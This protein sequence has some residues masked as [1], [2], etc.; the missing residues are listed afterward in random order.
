MDGSPPRA[1]GIRGGRASSSGCRRFTPTCV[2]N[3]HA[4]PQD[5]RYLSVHPHV[6]GEYLCGR[7]TPEIACGSPPRAWGILVG[8][9]RLPAAGRFTPTCVG[10][11]PER[12]NH[13]HALPVHPHVRGE[14]SSDV[15]ASTAIYGSPPRAW[16][17]LSSVAVLDEIA[18]FTPTCVGNTPPGTEPATAA[19]V[20]PHVRGEYMMMR[21]LA[22]DVAGSPPRAWGIRAVE[23]VGRGHVRFTPT[24][25]GNTCWPYSSPGRSSVH[26]HVRGE[27]H[28]RSAPWTRRT[29]SPPRAWGIHPR[30]PSIH[31]DRRFTPTCVG[32]TARRASASRRRSVHPH[33]RG[34]YRRISLREPIVAGSPP[35]AWGIHALPLDA[36][37][38][39]RFTPTCVGNTLLRVLLTP[40]APVHP[41]V[42]G[43]YGNS[44][45]GNI[46]SHGSPPRAWGIPEFSVDALQPRRFTPTCVGNTSA[47]CPA[48]ALLPVH[49]H[50]RGEYGPRAPMAFSSMRFTPTCVG[51]TSTSRSISASTAV[52]PHVRGEYGW[53]PPSAQAS[54]GSPP[55]AW[56]IRQVRSINV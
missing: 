19:P 1:W 32:N 38:D 36:V 17:I 45:R 2:G 12:R 37:L 41:H 25:V 28:P 6:R 10:N 23:L 48:Q 21:L 54:S 55:R 51:N 24:C 22:A 29:G 5:V 20:H 13:G 4:A 8:R 11:T 44:A 16:G 27:Y 30:R 7:A 3:T 42:R 34:E 26:P 46:S 40:C 31:A 14:Y 49:P 9:C 53:G 52:H 50:V 39:Y 15:L 33:V 35:R 47:G 56:G 18:R 43:E